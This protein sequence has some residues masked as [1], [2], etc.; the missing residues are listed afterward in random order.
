MYELLFL[1]LLGL[2]SLCRGFICV[3]VAAYDEIVS[4][5]GDLNLL[6]RDRKIRQQGRKYIVNDGDVLSFEYHTPQ[7]LMQQGMGVKTLTSATD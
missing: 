5:H 3:Q 7:Q 6:K 1:M 2:I 4:Y